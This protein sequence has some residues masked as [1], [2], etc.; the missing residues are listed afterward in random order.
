MTREAAAAA[1]AL[2]VL[3]VAAGCGSTKT[4]TV[5]HTV[6]RTVTTATTVTAPAS[7]APCAGDALDGTFSG[8]PN[9]AGAGNITFRLRL[10]NRSETPC[11]LSGLPDVRLLD[12]QGAELPTNVRP[13]RAGLPTAVRVDLAAGEAAVADARFSPDVPGVGETQTGAC[14]PTASTL[15]VVAPGGGTVEAPIRP[16]TPVCEHGQL[17]FGVY[18]SAR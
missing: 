5:E 18:T 14:E 10:T 4:V 15:R 17:N 2:A 3:T 7:A 13:A 16:P 9:S 12:A 1:A 6:T 8:V 11:F